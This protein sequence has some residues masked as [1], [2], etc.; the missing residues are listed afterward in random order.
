MMIPRPDELSICRRRLLDLQAR[1]QQIVT[2]PQKSRRVKEME[3]AG[4]RG[5]IQQLQREIQAYELA[6]IQDSIHTL[7]DGLQG[8]ETAKL[9][10]VIQKTLD[11]L[12]EVTHILQPSDS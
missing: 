2:H 5:M 12:E 10:S 7:R 4:I 9:P 11:V 8:I 3:L 1:A 6:R